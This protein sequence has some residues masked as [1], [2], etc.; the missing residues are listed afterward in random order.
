MAPCVYR[1]NTLGNYEVTRDHFTH[2][3]DGQTEIPLA[4]PC[5]EAGMDESKAKQASEGSGSHPSQL[6]TLPCAGGEGDLGPGQGRIKLMKSVWVPAW[7]VFCG[8]F[9][10]WCRGNLRL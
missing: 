2:F 8:L 7:L 3:I 5:N 10:C 4:G 6:W 1:L 9:L